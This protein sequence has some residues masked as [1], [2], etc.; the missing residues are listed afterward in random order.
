VLDEFYQIAFC[1]KIYRSINELQTDLDAWLADYNEQRPRTPITR[2]QL[3]RKPPQPILR[4]PLQ[5]PHPDNQREAL[6]SR[7]SVRSLFSAP[8]EN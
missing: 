1:K 4:H 5:R 7:L 3:G 6:H 8:I 2:E